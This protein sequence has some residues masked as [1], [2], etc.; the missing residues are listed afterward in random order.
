MRLSQRWLLLFLTILLEMSPCSPLARADVT[1]HRKSEAKKLAIEIGNAGLHKVYIADF[2]S[3]AGKREFGGCYLASAFATD[4]ADQAKNFE[5]VNR[6]YAQRILADLHLS[7]EGL[8]DPNAMAA[9]ARALSVDGILLGTVTVAKGKINISLSLREISSKRELAASS[10]EE[11]LELG[12]TANWPENGEPTFDTIYFAGLD[13]I[14]VPKCVTCP[15]PPYTTEARAA[16]FQG[17]VIIG[18]LITTEGK[19]TELRAI[20][21]PKNGLAELSIQFIRNWKLLPAKDANGKP[22]A[23]WVPIEV[24]FRLF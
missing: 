7:A 12:L 18:A 14:S 23:V 11:A 6:I 17:V 5:V 9:T 1:N 16:H 20:K 8:S 13:G 21:D 22:V 15:D 3:S 2:L 24:S 19:V 10:Y 4:I